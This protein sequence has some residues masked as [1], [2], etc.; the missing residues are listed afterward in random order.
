MAKRRPFSV[1]TYIGVALGRLG[2]CAVCKDPILAG[3][4]VPTKLQPDGP[5]V[6]VCHDCTTRKEPPR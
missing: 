5:T 4:R 3:D 1:V 6:F 2:Y